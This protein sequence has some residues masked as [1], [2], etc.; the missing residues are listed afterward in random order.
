ML[1][2]GTVIADIY[3]RQRG[4]TVLATLGMVGHQ[5]CEAL[6]PVAFGVVIDRAVRTG[7]GGAMW[8]SAAGLMLLFTAL[9]FSARGGHWMATK[10][11]VEESHRLRLEMVARILGRR[12]RPGDRQTGE[13]LSI[14]TSDALATTQIIEI[15]GWMIGATIGLGWTAFFLAR[16]DWVLCLGILIGVPLLML[17]LSRLG[18]RLERRTAHRQQTI[19][20]AAGMAADLLAGM[21]PLRGF[22]GVPETIRRYKTASR[23]SRDAHIAAIT[24]SAQFAGATS[25]SVGVLLAVVGGVVGLMA[26]DGRLMIGELVTVVGLAMFVSDPVNTISHLIPELAASRASAARVAELLSLEPDAS[27]GRAEGDPPGLAF[28]DVAAPGV[29]GLT[30]TLADGEVVGM[31]PSSAVAA[32]SLAALIDGSLAPE[33]GAVHLAGRPLVEPHAVHLFGAT[34]REALLVDADLEDGVLAEALS[35]VALNDI[36]GTVPSLDHVLTDHGTNLSGGQRQRIAMARALLAD[37][38]VLVL[39][40]PTTAVDAVTE[41][42]MADGIKHY[43]SRPGRTTVVITTSPPLLASCDRVVFVRPDGVC[44]PSTHAELVADPAYAELVL[45]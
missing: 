31:V 8:L 3:R 6:V 4:R 29:A 33:A 18:P 37:A 2:P 1:T 34:L 44:A 17:G 32:G 39:R 7:D 26:L 16:I 15:V 24:A 22:G 27:E 38:S 12:P 5:T 40:D 14:V 19:G 23:T 42:R 20:L 30:L 41:A 10:A 11:V 43:R 35:A 13:Q 45:R 9:T 25:F 21:R 36:A 28:A